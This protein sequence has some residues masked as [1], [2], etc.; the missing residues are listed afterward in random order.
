VEA[1]PQR[2]QHDVRTGLFLQARH[3]RLLKLGSSS[4]TTQQP[5]KPGR[6]PWISRSTV[7]MA[8]S[9][10]DHSMMIVSTS[11]TGS[12][13][14]CL[15]SHLRHAEESRRSCRRAGAH[16]PEGCSLHRRLE[17]AMHASPRTYR[18]PVVI[19]SPGG[20]NMSPPRP[21][22]A[23]RPAS[24]AGEPLDSSAVAS[25]PAADHGPL[26]HDVTALGWPPFRVSRTV[27]WEN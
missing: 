7:L 8:T 9:S 18:S 24:L 2:F 6:V 26:A 3:E 25:S 17:P 22:S 23:L 14:G 20:R 12:P 27:Q 10:G 19:I 21:A 13:P 16:E 1:S 4:A 11:T 5:G 15:G